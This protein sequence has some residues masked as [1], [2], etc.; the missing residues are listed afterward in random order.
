MRIESDIVPFLEGRPIAPDAWTAYLSL[1]TFDLPSLMKSG[2]YVTSRNIND[3]ESN[4]VTKFYSHKQQRWTYSRKYALVD[5]Q[6]SGKLEVCAWKMKPLSDF[7]IEDLSASPVNEARVDK[8]RSDDY[9]RTCRDLIYSFHLLEPN[10]R[11]NCF[12]GNMPMQGLWPWPRRENEQDEDKETQEQAGNDNDS[13][14]D[15]GM[16][17]PGSTTE[18]NTHSDMDSDT[19]TSTHTEMDNYIAGETDTGMDEPDWITEALNSIEAASN[20]IE[21]DFDSIRTDLKAD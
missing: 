15:P 18:L 3:M 20:S 1:E 7:R 13:E 8:E 17:T 11:I 10:E 12:Y 9:G 4:Y 6:W 5:P 19:D 16:D 2:L 14:T 21:A